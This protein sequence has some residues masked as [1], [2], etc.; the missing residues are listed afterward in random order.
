MKNHLKMVL[1]HAQICILPFYFILYRKHFCVPVNCSL[2]IWFFNIYKSFHIVS[3]Y[4]M[5]YITIKRGEYP[6]TWPDFQGT[7]IVPRMSTATDGLSWIVNIYLSVLSYVFK[8]KLVKRPKFPVA[9]KYNFQLF[10]WSKLI[11]AEGSFILSGHGYSLH[12]AKVASL[13]AAQIVLYPLNSIPP[14]TR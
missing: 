12:Q 8:K 4:D 2:K 1:P 5:I 7:S 6:Q 11:I 10:E 14:G 9:W 3:F 13:M